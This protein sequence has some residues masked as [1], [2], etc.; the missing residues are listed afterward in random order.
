MP[1]SPVQLIQPLVL[2]HAFRV[3]APWCTWMISNL[4]SSLTA[5]GVGLLLLYGMWMLVPPQ[6]EFHGS[7]PSPVS[8]LGLGR[9]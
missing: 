7:P 9:G 5:L 4:M 8:R 2:L 3:H 6:P 1:S